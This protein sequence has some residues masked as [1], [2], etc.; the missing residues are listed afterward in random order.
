MTHNHKSAINISRF[1]ALAFTVCVIAS[2]TG[3]VD[4][5]KFS[6]QPGVAPAATLP[7]SVG[8]VLSK[9]FKN[10]EHLTPLSL[11]TDEMHSLFGPALQQYSTYVAQS[12]FGNVQILDDQS[13]RNDVKLLLVPKVT[14][15]DLRPV[16]PGSQWTASGSLGVEWDF[17]D[18]KTN[19]KL[20]SMHIQSEATHTGGVF[21]RR[22][23]QIL[24]HVVES[25]FTNLTSTT[26]QRF[27][28]SKDIQRLSGH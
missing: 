19:E 16:T 2:S 10:Y 3:C 7:S 18:P 12:I 8:L 5:I 15:S 11:N 28:N 17:N 25:L 23:E 22:P 13:P 26:I 27:N 14:S 1:V 4:R 24:P 21:S 9:E 6:Y 20:F